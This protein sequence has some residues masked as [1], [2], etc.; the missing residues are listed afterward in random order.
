MEPVILVGDAYRELRKVKTGSVQCVVTSPPYFGLRDYGSAAEEV[1]NGSL[2]DYFDDLTMVMDELKR[3]L[4]DTGTVWFNIG[5]K[6]D[7]NGL[8]L[9]PAR[10][11]IR[12]R[13][14]GWCVRSDTIW[15]KTRY[16]PNGGK[17]RPVMIHEYLFMLTKKPRGYYYNTDALRTPHSPVSLKR[18]ES[19]GVA[20]LGAPKS[21]G[22]KKADGQYK[23]KK[24]VP[25]PLGKLATSVWDICPSNY[26]GA[27]FAVM[28]EEL[29]ERC[30]VASSR[31]GDRV[32]DPF[33]GA[34]TTGV[35]ALRLGRQFTGIEL[36]PE[37][38]TLAK[39]RMTNVHP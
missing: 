28:P 16:M 35:V 26:D 15:R 1:G 18:W 7:D 10:F 8:M 3:V 23:T 29:A 27:H 9:I 38:A 30:I 14:A 34:G 19:S 31:E 4:D 5:D 20:K 17:N 13:A 12:C 21:M 6:Y 32:L 36:Y 39:R 11:A 2:T 22:H 37:T 33:M 25:H 24:V